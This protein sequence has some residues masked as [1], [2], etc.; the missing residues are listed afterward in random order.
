MN[1]VGLAHLSHFFNPATEPGMLR[2]TRGC[3]NLYCGSSHDDEYFSRGAKRRLGRRWIKTGS[4]FNRAAKSGISS[5]TARP[6]LPF[7]KAALLFSLT[8]T[9]YSSE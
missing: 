8:C 5:Y 4:I 2:I 9:H 6:K 1:S 7:A 3:L